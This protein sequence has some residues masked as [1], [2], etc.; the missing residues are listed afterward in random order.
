MMKM[1]K[2][3][4]WVCSCWG[5]TELIGLIRCVGDDA[6][7]AYVQDILIK[8]KYQRNG[9]GRQILEKSFKRFEA[10]RQFVLLTDDTQKT[11][12]FYNS[13]GMREVDSVDG[14]CFVKYRF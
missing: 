5:G 10:V 3:S 11:K 6:T 2:N 12:Q 14:C 8:P 7:I 9:I 1:I 4:L 13:L